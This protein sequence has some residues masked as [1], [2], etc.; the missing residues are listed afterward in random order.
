MTIKSTFAAAALCL[1]SSAA[2]AET[3]PAPAPTA[4]PAAAADA[5]GGKRWEAC[6][7]DVQKFCANLEKGKGVIRTCLESHKT[8]L[9]DACK[10][11]MAD[12]AA[13]GQS[14]PAN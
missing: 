14:K 1:V 4:A 13:K 5:T 12:H 3:A 8:E 9:S 7:A 2:I 6:K 11:S 10:T